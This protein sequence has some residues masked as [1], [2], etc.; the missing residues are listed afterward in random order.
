MNS[1]HV[2]DRPGQALKEWICSAREC[3]I[4]FSV[5][6]SLR[7]VKIERYTWETSNTKLDGTGT[8]H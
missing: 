3:N 7:D 2:Q 5:T 6:G 8:L 1:V 4:H